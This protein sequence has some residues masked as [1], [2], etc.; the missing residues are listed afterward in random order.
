MLLTLEEQL[1]VFPDD[2]RIHPAVMRI[3]E[4]VERAVW[5][6]VRAGYEDVSP[7]QWTSAELVCRQNWAIYGP[8]P[9]TNRL[10]QLL[11]KKCSAARR[12]LSGDLLVDAH[13][14][15]QALVL[16]DETGQWR[17][18]EGYLATSDRVVETAWAHLGG[19]VLGL[20]PEPVG[21][22]LR[23]RAV[24]YLVRGRYPPDWR[25]VGAE[26]PTSILRDI[27]PVPDG[28]RVLSRYDTY[29]GDLSTPTEHTT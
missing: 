17:Y 26:I 3:A 13:A 6:K 2:R 29:Y 9:V 23:A 10:A 24:D 18:C 1:A 28:T 15:A 12:E 22:P 14:L 20:A 5:S 4:H 11:W 8:V 25:F 7:T 16:Y 27:I 21:A 19:L